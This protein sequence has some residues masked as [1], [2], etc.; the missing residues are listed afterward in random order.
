MRP[1]AAVL[2]LLALS[3]SG[4]AKSRSHPTAP[5]PLGQG[6]PLGAAGA[7]LSGNHFVWSALTNEIVGSGD[8]STLSL[9]A[10]H[11]TTGAT[12]VLDSAAALLPVAP[13]AGTPVYYEALLLDP[14]L[15]GNDSVALRRVSLGGGAPVQ[16]DA[17][18]GL[19]LYAHEISGDGDWLAWGRTIGLF[20]S[21]SLVIEATAT[22]ARSRIE[23]GFPILVSPDGSQF[24]YRTDLLPGMKLRDRVAGTSAPF[25]LGLPADARLAGMRWDAGGLHALYLLGKGQLHVRHLASGTSE[26]LYS[27]SDSLVSISGTWSPNGARV[28]LWSDVPAVEPAHTVSLH[29]VDVAAKNGAVVATGS[30]TASPGFPLLLGAIAFSPDSRRVAYQYA[31]QVFTHDF[32]VATAAAPGFVSLAGGAALA[33]RSPSEVARLAIARARAVSVRARLS[34]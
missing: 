6:T 19:E 31:D 29:V 5:Q 7:F 24:L 25:D 22:G 8:I 13:A 20:T 12:R 32:P 9:V 21:D 10:M 11:G 4:C 17:I 1:V 14:T 23:P 33:A 15:T 27:A 30:V 3:A 34:P 16:L 2:C 18:P 28:A 26:A